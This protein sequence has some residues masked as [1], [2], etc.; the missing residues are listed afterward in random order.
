MSQFTEC[1]GCLQQPL[2]WETLLSLIIVQ[3]TDGARYLNL[4]FNE[5]LDDCDEY[6]PVVNCASPQTVLEMFAMLI[7]EDECG[8]CALNFKSN[9]CS[10]CD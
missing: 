5:C 1:V 4:N 6:T 7:V 9:I 8:N 10:A 3:D 2:T